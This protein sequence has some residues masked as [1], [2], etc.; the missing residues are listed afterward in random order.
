MP[1]AAGAV[2]A[3]PLAG[4]VWML[5]QIPAPD[6]ADVAARSQREPMLH[7]ARSAF[8]RHHG[9]GLAL[10]I[11]LYLF[12]TILRSLRSDF[13]PEIWRAL[14]VKIDP[15]VFTR[16][17]IWVALGVVGINCLAVLIRDNRRA[18]FTALVTSV[19]G[20]ALAGGSVLA[21]QAGLAGGLPFMVLLGLGIYIPYVAVH[22]T[23]FERLIAL[24]R[25]RANIGYLMYLADALGY[26]GYVAVMFGKRYWPV[27]EGFLS[28]FTTLTLILAFFGTIAIVGAG[29]YFR[30]VRQPAFQ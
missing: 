16:S 10:I 12:V 3:A 28:F 29:L 18:F 25:E 21:F 6:T 27:P 15:A 14:G 7:S 22:T 17:E 30:R 8:L 13:A 26:L 24:T 1:S 11:L 5:S 9:V 23:V 2:F 4:F 19:A 20:L